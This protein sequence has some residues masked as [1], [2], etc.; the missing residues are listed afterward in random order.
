MDDSIKT[1]PM[2]PLRSLAVLPGMVLH[3]DISREKSV[4]AV[5]AAMAEDQ[6]IFLVTQQNPLRV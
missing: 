4:R 1:M 5:E 6:N 2:I 3:F